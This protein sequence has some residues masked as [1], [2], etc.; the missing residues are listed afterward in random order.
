[1]WCY[2]FLSTRT[3]MRIVNI[4]LH[5]LPKPFACQYYV[6][7]FTETICLSILCYTF[8]RNHL[9]VNIMLHILPKPFAC[10][11][12]D[13]HFTETICLLKFLWQI[14]FIILIFIVMLPLPTEVQSEYCILRNAKKVSMATFIDFAIN[15]NAGAYN[16]NIQIITD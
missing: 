5:I 8:Y 6:T 9:L 10:Q 12:Y 14:L 3:I 1:M 11:Y 16:I 2:K 7:H 13:T 4:M 15:S